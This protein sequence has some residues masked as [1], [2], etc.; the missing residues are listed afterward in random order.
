[1]KTKQFLGTECVL[2]DF[3]KYD[4]VINDYVEMN[5]YINKK[6]VMDHYN[7]SSNDELEKLIE[8]ISSESVIMLI[9]KFGV[10]GF[11]TNK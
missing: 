2:F 3:V 11:E 9:D 4:E 6:K 5:A 1:M 8:T 7:L 10:Y